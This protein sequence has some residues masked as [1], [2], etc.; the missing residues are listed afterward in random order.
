[1]TQYKDDNVLIKGNFPF[2]TCH[3]NMSYCYSMSLNNTDAPPKLD[4]G[5]IDTQPK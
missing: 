2:S 3:F 4:Q 1:M 5:P